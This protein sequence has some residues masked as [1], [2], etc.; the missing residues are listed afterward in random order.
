MR[1]YIC[2]HGKAHPDSATGRDFD[3]QLN[4]RGRA[5]VE[6]LAGALADETPRAPLVVASPYVRTQQT[7]AAIAE[8]LE[9]DLCNDER[10][11]VDAG[12]HG[13]LSIIQHQ[14]QRSM[15]AL[16]LVGHNPDLSEL[17]GVLLQGPLGGGAFGLKTGMCVAC[18]VSSPD[19]VGAGSEASVLRLEED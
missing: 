8:S 4:E 3:R 14:V 7:A 19:P 17:V 18:T 5:Q 12:L 11:A 9:A 16:V 15:P 2:R 13:M 6:Y 10:L 1:L